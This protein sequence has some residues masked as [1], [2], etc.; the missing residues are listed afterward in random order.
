[1]PV[2]AAYLEMAER[3]IPATMRAVVAAGGAAS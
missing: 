3:S 2:H 1:M